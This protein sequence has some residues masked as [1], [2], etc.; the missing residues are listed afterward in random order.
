MWEVLCGAVRCCAVLCCAAVL[1]KEE[2]RK[3]SAST[4]LIEGLLIRKRN[5]P[6]LSCNPARRNGAC[7]DVAVV[8]LAGIVSC[9]R[10]VF[11]RALNAKIQVGASGSF[12]FQTEDSVAF[13]KDGAPL[14][15]ALVSKQTRGRQAGRQAGRRQLPRGRRRRT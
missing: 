1:E 10:L 4:Y 6:L 3:E 2:R 7:V 14:G 9:C 12:C 5:P 13:I 11:G 15:L 8:S